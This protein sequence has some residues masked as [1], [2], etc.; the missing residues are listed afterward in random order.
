MPAHS[1]VLASRRTILLA[2]LVLYEQFVHE[3]DAERDAVEVEVRLGRFEKLSKDWESI[4]QQLEDQTSNAE[5]IVHNAA[6]R[7]DFE[8]RVIR[9]QSALK[10]EW[11]E[12]SRL[13]NAQPRPG[14]NP[15][16][17]IKLPTIALP[18]FD[19]DYMQWLTFRDTFEC[20]IHQNDDLP[21]IQKFHYLR[22]AVKG[23]AAQVIE[24]ITISASNY[25]LAWRMLTERYSNEYLLKKR[26]LQAMF[27]IAPAKKESASTLHQLVDEFQRHKKTLDH[28][29]EDTNT[30][31]SILEHLLCTNLPVSTLRDW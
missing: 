20:L 13:Q 8:A 15:L 19:G 14:G 5:E 4:Q 23:E 27:G 26:H 18:E 3:Y 6:L 28:L 21:A 22:A 1:T 16:Q 30:W 2:A 7:E 9:V 25:D 29:G 17:G 10:R 24:A 12:I 31:S 11:K